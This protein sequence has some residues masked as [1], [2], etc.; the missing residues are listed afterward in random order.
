MLRRDR[1]PAGRTYPAPTLRRPLALL[2]A[3]GCLSAAAAAQTQAV[4]LPDQDTYVQDTNPA[5]NFG[6]DDLWFGRG[7]FFGLGNIRT[8]V[9]FDFS[10]FQLDPR[11]I[12]SASFNAY[13][14]ATEPAAGGLPCELHSA[15]APWN[16]MTV[17]WNNQPA[18]DA[19]VWAAADVGDSFGVGLVSWDVTELVRAQVDGTIPNHG[20]LFRMQF[21]TAGAS[22]LG[23]FYSTETAPGA[24]FAPLLSV[25]LYEM[26]L[27]A[28]PLAAGQAA[29]VMVAGARPGRRV[30]FAFSTTG[31]GTTPVPQLNV[32]LD[33]DAARPLASDFAGGTGHASRRFRVPAA[34]LGRNYWLQACSL[35]KLSNVVSGV[36]Q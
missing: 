19:Q 24:L 35:G 34:A 15:T 32:T 18:Y 31:L 9:Q 22:R 30:V 6:A 8:L 23:Y 10:R 4:L 2:L 25:E 7:S 1:P 3:A 36:V 29:T 33:L 11:L 16:E 21:E 12:K 20:W 27:T 26:L 13:Q 28:T 5:S 17:T 14:Y